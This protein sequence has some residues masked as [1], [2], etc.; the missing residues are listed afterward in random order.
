MLQKLWRVYLQQWNEIF[1][2][3]FLAGRGQMYGRGGPTYGGPGPDY[4]QQSAAAPPPQ[5]I[6]S[7]GRG[8]KYLDPFYFTLFL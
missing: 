7:Y 3:L 8:K 6:P 4:G 1:D 5:Q 2:V